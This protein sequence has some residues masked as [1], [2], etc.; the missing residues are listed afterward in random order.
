MA[1]YKEGTFFLSLVEGGGVE[2]A[3]EKNPCLSGATQQCCGESQAWYIVLPWKN[4]EQA[5]TDSFTK[6]KAHFSFTSLPCEWKGLV[7][8]HLPASHGT[9]SENL[10]VIGGPPY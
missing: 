10:P 2:L 1:K 3:A 9:T 7:T 8:A 4:W 5:E 6:R